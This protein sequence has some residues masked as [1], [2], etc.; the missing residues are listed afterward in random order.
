MRLL[1]YPLI[2]MDGTFSTYQNISKKNAL[3]KLKELIHQV[4]LYQGVFGFLWHNSS[5]NTPIY[6]P[7][8]G[9][10]EDLLN[11]LQKASSG[12]MNE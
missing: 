9:L 12:A 7:Y 5:F 6:E 3:Q 1:E 4:K 10:Y 8:E 11:L 2:F